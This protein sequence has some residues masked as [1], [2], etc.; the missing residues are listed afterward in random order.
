MH[1]RPTT[2]AAAIAVATA[3]AMALPAA[4]TAHLPRT[5]SKRIVPGRSM[6]G[7]KLDMSRA[8][9]FG[10]WGHA[11][12]D[13]GVCTWNGPGS[14][15]HREVAVVSFIKGNV[16]LISIR[17]GSRGRNHKFKE[18]F[19]SDWV[20]K[21][22]ISLGSPKGKVPRAYPHAKP[23][24]GEA[25]QGFDLFAGSGRN[26]RYTRFGTPGIGASPHRLWGISIQWDTCHYYAPSCPRQ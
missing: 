10:K 19:L 25:V 11:P 24:N 2:R 22:H 18:G 21:K 6:A 7:V 4:A 20:T 1:A 15:Q 23:N 12:C 17:A 8:Q 16:D 13:H 9:V 26:L 14:A 3:T 5:D